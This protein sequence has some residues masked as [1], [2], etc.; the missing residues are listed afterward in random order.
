LK[1]GQSLAEA[2]R[3]VAGAPWSHLF[4]ARGARPVSPEFLSHRND[5]HESTE[6]VL[7]TRDELV[8][9]L[10]NEGETFI[11]HA[12]GVITLERA[13]ARLGQPII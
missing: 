9:A 8:R 12:L 5:E 1:H 7:M 6:A 3:F 11:S 4:L 10:R 13:L 2:P